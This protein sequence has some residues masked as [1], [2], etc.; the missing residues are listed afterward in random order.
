MWH[1]PAA[2]LPCL[3]S[4]LDTGVM[5]QKKAN[6]KTMKQGKGG[7]SFNVAACDEER[8]IF[9]LSLCLPAFVHYLFDSKPALKV[10]S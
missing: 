1:T 4:H 3:I 2:S 8:G 10:E 7:E 9:A 5:L 6:K